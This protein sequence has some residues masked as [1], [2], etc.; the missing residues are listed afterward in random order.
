MSPIS[1]DTIAIYSCS[2]C[3]RPPGAAERK[4]A[5]ACL[6][7]HGVDSP[8]YSSQNCAYLVDWLVM[9]LTLT[10]HKVRLKSASITAG[11]CGISRC[12]ETMITTGFKDSILLT[13]SLVNILFK[14]G[15]RLHPTKPAKREISL[16]IQ[17]TTSCHV[18]YTRCLLWWCASPF[19]VMVFVRAVW[20]MLYVC[21][22]CKKCE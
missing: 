19:L 15:F 3:D 8:T 4:G 17:S 10:W 22:K 12:P 2:G 11:S 6:S 5:M 18:K 7:A 14:Q 21:F 16:K 9:F 1:G 13:G 20:E